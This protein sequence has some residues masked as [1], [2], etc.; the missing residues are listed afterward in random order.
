MNLAIVLLLLGI[1]CREFCRDSITKVLD[2]QLNENQPDDKAT[3]SIGQGNFGVVYDMGDGTVLKVIKHNQDTPMIRIDFEILMMTWLNNIQH[4]GN[5]VIPTFFGDC[6]YTDKHKDQYTV[7]Q[8][9][10][11]EQTL[12]DLYLSYKTDTERITEKMIE[13]AKILQTIN[14]QNFAHLDSHGSN[15]MICDGVMKLIDLGQG[16]T[17]AH[18]PLETIQKI[19]DVEANMFWKEH[20]IRYLTIDHIAIDQKLVNQLQ[21]KWTNLK[22]LKSENQL[23]TMDDVLNVLESKLRII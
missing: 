21:S 18:W 17:M 14:N 7:I 19:K 16:K 15:F 9:K 10:K 22:T 8:V 23:M 20:V 6:K 11:C 2:K 5:S 1:R 13:A 12:R 4:N 3:S